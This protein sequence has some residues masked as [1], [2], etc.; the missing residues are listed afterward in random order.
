MH[1]VDEINGC[2]ERKAGPHHPAPP[3]RRGGSVRIGHGHRQ[4]HYGEREFLVVRPGPAD[5]DVD[6]EAHAYQDRDEESPPEQRQEEGHQVFRAIPGYS[7]LIEPLDRRFVPNQEETERLQVVEKDTL[8]AAFWSGKAVGM[9]NRPEEILIEVVRRGHTPDDQHH[10]DGE[11][12][13]LVKALARA[14]PAQAEVGHAEEKQEEDRRD[15]ERK[16]GAVQRVPTH[17]HHGDPESVGQHERQ[18]DE[19]CPHRDAARRGGGLLRLGGMCG[20]GGRRYRFVRGLH[21]AIIT[22]A[23]ELDKPRAGLCVP[24]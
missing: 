7:A 8:V 6:A 3:E 16:A 10:V 5:E 12:L 15:E 21:G 14:Q 4:L 19:Y 23:R 24:E 17:L 2:G 20:V 13:A 22:R 11:Q 9:R 1:A 18:P